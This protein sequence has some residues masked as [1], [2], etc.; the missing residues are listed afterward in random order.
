[1]S[2]PERTLLYKKAVLWYNETSENQNTEG[3][4]KSWIIQIISQAKLIFQDRTGYFVF[5]FFLSVAP[6]RQ[7][8]FLF[9]DR[10]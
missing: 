8:F 3:S 9:E 10:D 5:K 6:V 1:M 2:A 4:A 7:L